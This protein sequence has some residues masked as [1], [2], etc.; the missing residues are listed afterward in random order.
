MTLHERRVLYLDS[1][2]SGEYGWKY[3][4]Q[5]MADHQCKNRGEAVEGL[6]REHQEMQNEMLGNR[7]LA[8]QVATEIKQLIDPIRLRTGSTERTV[9]MFR[10]LLNGFLVLHGM[11]EQFPVT[12]VQSNAIVRA[13]EKIADQIKAQQVYRNSDKYKRMKGGE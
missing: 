13:D 9:A 12:D 10:E 5:Y 7:A 4:D 3:I 1:P 11:E 6:L 8:R 2:E